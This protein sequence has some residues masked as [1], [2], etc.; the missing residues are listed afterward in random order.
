MREE[1]RR[2]GVR[3]EPSV[4]LFVQ[5]NP[6]LWFTILSWCADPEL[7]L[8]AEERVWATIRRDRAFH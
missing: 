4:H 7:A 3:D 8:W 1:A 6:A 2:A 5:N